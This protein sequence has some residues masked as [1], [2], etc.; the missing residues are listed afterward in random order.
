MGD[1]K[2][3]KAQIQANRDVDLARVYAGTDRFKAGARAVIWLGVAGAFA[4]SIYTLAGKD[5][6][7]EALMEATFKFDVSKYAFMAISALTGAGWMW[8]KRLRKTE[9]RE[10]SAKCKQYEILIDPK[11]SSSFLTPEGT[12]GKESIAEGVVLKRLPQGEKN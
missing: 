4:F 9:V 10:L 3:S 1:N 5:T 6:N 12:P 11:R 8:E 7:F 2:L